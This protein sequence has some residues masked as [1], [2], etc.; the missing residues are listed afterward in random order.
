MAGC[1]LMAAPVGAAI[2]LCFRKDKTMDRK[3]KLLAVGVGGLVFIMLII[4]FVVSCN[5]R[6]KAQPPEPTP[7][8]TDII[9]ATPTPEIT[10]T[11]VATPTITPP[12]AQEL[13]TG[14]SV[15]PTASPAVTPKPTPIQQDLPSNPTVTPMPKPGNTTKPST[16]TPSGSDTKAS[17]APAFDFG[18]PAVA[19][20]NAQIAVQ[21]SQKNIVSV[22][23]SVTKD[24]IL[25]LTVNSSDMTGALTVDGGTI[26]FTKAGKY[27]LTA[28]ARNNVGKAVTV[29][30]AIE[31]YAPGKFAFGL[32]QAAYTDTAVDVDVLEGADGNVAWSISKDGASVSL[33]EAV[34]GTLTDN[35]GM[36]TFRNEG[37][38]VLT[39]KTASGKT[40]TDSIQVYPL[41]RF[42]FTLPATT[43][44]NNEFAVTMGECYLNGQ[45]LAWSMEK[46]GRAV[47]LPANALTSD[48]GKLSLPELGAYSL[49]ASATDPRTGRMFIQTRK[50]TV[51]N[52]A[53]AITGAIATVTATRSGNK[54]LVQFSAAALDP[55]EDETVLEWDGRT[56]DDLYTVGT[57]TLRVRAK[58]AV[59][60]YSPWH[61]VS[62]EVPNMPPVITASSATEVRS[63]IRNAKVYVEM[64][65]EA[66][67]PDGDP[68]SLEWDGRANGDYYGLGDHTVRVRARDSFG[69]YSDWTDVPFSIVNGAPERPG[70]IRTPPDGIIFP[71][72]NVTVNAQS[73][74]PDGDPVTYV[75]EGRPAE[76]FAYP[77]GR[78]IVKVKAVDPFGTESKTKRVM[79]IMGD[80][81]RAGNLMLTG[82]DS[83]LFEP[84]I[85]DAT[86][87]YYKFVVPPVDGHYGQDFGRVRGYNRLT[88]QWDQLDYGT[89]NN[90]ISFE[91]NLAAGTYTKLDLYYYTNHDCMYHKSNITYIALFEFD[92]L[93]DE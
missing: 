93:E 59:G 21:T 65:A 44:R 67:D 40:H 52:Q 43:Y 32:P 87:I 24:G 50:I 17:T 79:W 31:V 66:S 61:D 33:V 80:P 83:S 7:T 77:E 54:A 45:A 69:A 71:G 39:G 64:A 22:D 36:V 12:P 11:P 62:F 90:G 6:R 48:G 13:P 91:R 9:G 38:Y 73:T 89:T 63:N 47:E 1:F 25:G 72:T 2:S 51:I 88:G 57:H 68:V 70:I 46:A 15:T 76:V 28:V 78:V 60:A 29:A 42:P 5:A 27:T 84:G 56:A 49:T 4:I 58:D 26:S 74:D 41:L 20:T 18:L 86:L 19:T 34:S 3:T 8:P 23:W 81:N 75:W 16:T 92:E 30:S 55:D 10:P 37:K 53:P 82:P 14:P 35:G 85:E